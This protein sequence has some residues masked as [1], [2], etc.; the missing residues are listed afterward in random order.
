MSAQVIDR[1]GV[2]HFSNSTVRG[3]VEE[4]I[5]TLLQGLDRRYFRLHLVC[6]PENEENMR[7]D[8]PGDVEIIPL[9]LSSPRDGLAAITLARILRSRRIGILHSHM[10]WAS[11]FASPVGRVCGVPVILETPHIRESWRRGWKA[12]FWIDRFVGRFVTNYVCVSKA[13]LRYLVDAKGLP[14]NKMTVVYSGSDLRRYDPDHPYP[15]ALKRSLG[16]DDDDPVL[17]VVARLEPQK[18]HRVLLA[19]MRSVL[20]R[21]PRLRVVCV[22]DGAVRQELEQQAAELG[23]ND[24]V[25]FVGYQSNPADWYA[26]AKFTV[27]PSFFEGLPLTC[28]ESLAS[29]RTMVAT[30]VDGTPEII[31]DGKTGL[32]VPPGDP[33]RLAEAIC[34][35]LESAEL[36]GQFARAGRE[37]VTKRF[38]VA[39]FVEDT[40]QL[41]LRAW[42]QRGKA[43]PELTATATTN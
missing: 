7:A 11:L 10:F 13:N 36:C 35:L 23:L 30:A 37:L 8:V 5:L 42:T 43:V 25:R 41:Y 22:G 26:M 39:R 32:T 9:R 38:S 17:V 3:G 31:V 27:L 33:A 12:K 21:H 40:Q 24:S 6:T 19:A 34:R 4:H 2:L 18:G 14:E 28:I 29:G 1:I 15:T 20:E 16:F